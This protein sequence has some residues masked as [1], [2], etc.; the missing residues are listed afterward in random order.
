MFEDVTNSICKKNMASNATMSL[1]TWGANKCDFD[2]DEVPNVRW[3]F[4]LS[5]S[6]IVVYKLCS[7]YKL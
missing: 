4:S 3:Y 7:N 2:F 6:G 1:M 5:T